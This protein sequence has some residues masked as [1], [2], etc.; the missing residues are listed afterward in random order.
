MLQSALI[1]CATRKAW[2]EFRDPVAQFA[3]RDVRDIPALLATLEASVEANAYWAVGFLT[4]EAAGAF[5]DALITHASAT[6]PLAVFSLFR[7]PVERDALPSAEGSAPLTAGW[8][9]SIPREEY[10]RNI[11]TIKE[12]IELGNTYQVNLTMQQTADLQVTAWEFFLRIADGA[13]YAAYLDCG[14]T[15]VVS[16]SPE[17]FFSLDGT[18]VTCKPMKGTAKRGLTQ[19]ADLTQRN[20]L[21]ASNKNQAENVMI[22]DMIRNDLGRIARPGSVSATAL[23][24]IE[25]YRTVWQMTSTVNAQTDAGLADM[26]GALFPSASITGAPKASSMRIIQSLER[27]PRELYT[28]TIGYFAPDR[29]AQFN[30]A[31][32]TARI[33]TA[34]RKADYGIGSGIVWD[35]DADAEFEECLAKARVLESPS[36]PADLELFETLRWTPAAGY[37]L[38]EEHLQ[39]LAGSAGYFDIPWSE[40]RARQLLSASEVT[41]GREGRRVRLLLAAD[42]TFRLQSAALPPLDAER[43]WQLGLATSPVDARDPFLYHKTT[44]RDVYDQASAGTQD[45]DDVLLYNSDGYVT[46]TTIANVVFDFD[47]QRVTP[48]VS[49]GLLPGTYRAHLLAN[50]AL[51]E[52]PVHRDQLYDGMPVTLIN[53]LRGEFRARLVLSD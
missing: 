12:Q 50:G 3:V 7:A 10:R 39:R 43:C 36:P 52:Q 20:E 9:L 27:G 2:L 21:A 35:S 14:R 24:D 40:S 28:G 31:I 38:L 37:W 18:T 44:Y 49:H 48:P 42:G 51:S 6:L 15:A 19:A 45:Y 53:A 8:A 11:A 17:L 5:D 26:I 4:Y 23:Y 32:R 13:P 41:M 1:R 16:A 30:V 34:T 25:K 29:R 33:D 22:T 47:G 46:E